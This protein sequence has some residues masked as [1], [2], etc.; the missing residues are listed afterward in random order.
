MK[1]NSIINPY[2][3]F[4]RTTKPL[5]SIS[6]QA[7][8]TKLITLKTTNALIKPSLNNNKLTMLNSINHLLPNPTTI[9][10]YLP[11]K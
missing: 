7:K 4:N 5:K 11:N 8:P 3:F 10:N 2:T 1:P 6:I 9:F